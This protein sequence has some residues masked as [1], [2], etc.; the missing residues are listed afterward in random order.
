MVHFASAATN[1]KENSAVLFLDVCKALD[2]VWHTRLLWK[3]ASAGVPL[4]IL[5]I[6]TTKNVA[7]RQIVQA[8]R[9]VRNATIQCDLRVEGLDEH[10]A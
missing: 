1:R 3:I 9:F 8:P 2:R 4:L 10:I 7:L 6:Q 5:R